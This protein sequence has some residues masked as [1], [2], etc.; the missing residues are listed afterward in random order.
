MLTTISILLVG[1]FILLN[2]YRLLNIAGLYITYISS[3]FC[4]LLK[5]SLATSSNAL[6]TLVASLAD[7]SK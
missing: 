5:A 1:L 3:S 2:L 6:S 4:S 7:V